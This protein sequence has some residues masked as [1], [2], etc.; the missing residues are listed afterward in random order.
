[1]ALRS[2]SNPNMVFPNPTPVFLQLSAFR[3]PG[4]KIKKKI[5]AI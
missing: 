3:N 2:I 1:M 5:Q 4:F